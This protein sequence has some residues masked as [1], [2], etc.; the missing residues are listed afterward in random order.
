MSI[1][2]GDMNNLVQ[3]DRVHRSLYVEPEI[4]ELEI[5]RIFGRAWLYVGHE[6]QVPK[7]SAHSRNWAGHGTARNRRDV[8]PK[9]TVGT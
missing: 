6:S 5:D 3:P 4:F 1:N 8:D 2:A 7:P 9:K